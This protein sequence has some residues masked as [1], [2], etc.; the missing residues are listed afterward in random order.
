MRG[1]LVLA[2]NEVKR[3][4]RGR[5]RPAALIIMVL[6]PLLYGGLYLWAFWNPY[7]NFDKVPVALVNLDQP[8][9]GPQGSVDAGAA[10]EAKLVHGHLLDWTP[11][12]ER[13]AGRGV[14]DGHYYAALLIPPNFSASIVSLSSGDPR[15]ATL[16]TELNAAS[17]YIASQLMSSVFEALRSAAATT[18]STQ[19]LEHIFVS[20]ARSGGAAQKAAG[21]AAQLAAGI[22]GASAGADRLVPGLDTA[23]GAT[24][25]LDAALGRLSQGAQRLAAGLSSLDGGL[26]SLARHGSALPPASAALASGASRVAAGTAQSSAGIAK[27]STAAGQLASAAS[28]LHTLIVLYEASDP[29][30]AASPLYQRIVSAAQALANGMAALS[31]GLSQAVPGAAKL[32]SGA[33]VVAQGAGKLAAL[34]P[35]LAG[36]ISQAAGGAARLAPG[37]ASLGAGAAA[38]Q[39]GA[40]RLGGGLTRLSAGSS[41][42]RSGLSQL[43][44]GAGR[45]ASGLGAAAHR[46]APFSTAGSPARA[47]LFADPVALLSRELHPVPNYGTAFAPYFIP[48]ALW[49]GCLML[50]FL[51]RPL[52]RRAMAL[53]TAPL[54]VA[55]GG[56]LPVAAL[57]VVQ[58][59]L[60]LVVVQGALGLSAAHPLALWAFAFLSA[61][62]FAAVIQVLEALLGSAGRVVALAMLIL[63]LV[64]SAGT[65]PIQTSPGFIRAIQPFLPM[66][67]MVNGMRDAV[68]G[69]LPYLG[70]DV[71]VLLMWLGAS[72]AVT[73]RSARRGQVLTYKVLYPEIEMS[74]S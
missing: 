48:L 44:S 51:L 69:S 13:S 71:L 27:A 63:Q 31:S 55:L 14:A 70:H 9:H 12:S 45:L 54:V 47:A 34:A 56:L 25:T 6:I 50:F 19:V 58:A 59:V 52:S 68:S 74:V 65:Y 28:Q 46:T 8:A 23:G 11:S 40:G 66:T 39:S 21:G 37:A 49:V 62:T 1:A 43:R 26:A 20:L 72:L 18:F 32:A 64:S 73:T 53:G 30:A 29:L 16:T 36:G 3:F 38:A 10:L 7:G 22:T 41:S 42:L 24:A 4:A 15:P 2:L 35:R 5:T 57:S 33:A 67:Y 60:V 61:V 17:N